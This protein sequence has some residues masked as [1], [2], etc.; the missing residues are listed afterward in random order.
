MCT[1]RSPLLHAIK[2]YPPTVPLC[3][4]PTPHYGMSS[5]DLAY[6]LAAPPNVVLD[7]ST[8]TLLSAYGGF[9]IPRLPAYDA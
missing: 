6:Y 5:T 1:F 3:Y 4:L 2:P 9:E 8:P 7:G